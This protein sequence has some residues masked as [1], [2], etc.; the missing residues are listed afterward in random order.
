LDKD[1]AKVRLDK[2]KGIIDFVNE[3]LKNIFS[4]NEEQ[5]EINPTIDLEEVLNKGTST[6]HYWFYKLDY[7]LWKDYK[8]NENKVERIYWSGFKILENAKIE[9]FKLSRLNSIEHIFPQNPEV[10][11]GEWDE[12][13]CSK[14][15]FGNLA[16]IS[17]HL[18]STF[19]NQCFEN[20][21][22]DLEKQ[23]SRGTIESLKLLLV[24]SK[25]DKWNEDNCKEHYNE[26]I[27]L[28]KNSLNNKKTATIEQ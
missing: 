8:G 27:N 18:N 1:F 17:N 4:K 7:L 24:Y 28:L 14:D 26:M 16:L 21:K 23:L 2:N 19:S 6:P 15:S 3:K 22:R 13:K 12:E 5:I 9:N 11:C 10:F 25:Y 20:K